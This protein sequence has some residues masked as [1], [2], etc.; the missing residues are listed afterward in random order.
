MDVL[1]VAR[2]KSYLRPVY[3]RNHCG[4]YSTI[5]TIYLD[6]SGKVIGGKE[7]ER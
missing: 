7:E 6:F 4:V 2:L 1:A 5:Q 3:A